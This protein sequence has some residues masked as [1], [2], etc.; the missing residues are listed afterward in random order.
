MKLKNKFSKRAAALV[1]V[2]FA[3]ANL[4]AAERIS[5]ND[6]WRFAKGDPEGVGAG[7]SYSNT[8]AWLLPTANAFRTN[9]PAARP[10][11]NLGE[12]ISFAQP[13]FDDTGWRRL[14]LPHDFG[15][16]G[17][18]AW[19][20]PGETGKLPWARVAWYRKKFS[21]P[22][23]DSGKILSLDVDGAMAYAT[24]WL[25]GHCVGGWPYGYASWRVDLTP[26]VKFGG[27]NSLAIRLDNPKE[28]SR[29]YPGGGIYRNVWLV[30]SAPVHVGALGS[31]A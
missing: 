18:F 14:N 5:F 15:I 22:A 10:D 21:V 28:S 23:S 30:K 2:L 16:E 11:G 17:P 9:A 13:G 8:R 29:W 3:A 19:E 12:N 1:A 26:F 24:V 6:D 4:F 27:E 7:L 20:L 31:A 25:N